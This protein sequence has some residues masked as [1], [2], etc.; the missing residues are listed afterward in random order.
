MPQTILVSVK[1]I[2]DFE[3]KRL[4]SASTG[5][6]NGTSETKTFRGN[7]L[8]KGLQK[9]NSLARKIIIAVIIK[10]VLVIVAGFGIVISLGDNQMYNTYVG[11]LG[12]T[13][14]SWIIIAY[15]QQFRLIQDLC[16]A[17]TTKKSGVEYMKSI[18]GGNNLQL[19]GLLTFKVRQTRLKR[20]KRR[21][22]MRFYQAHPRSRLSPRKPLDCDQWRR[23]M[24]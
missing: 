3:A 23:W 15:Y 18:K 17:A 5:T 13:A 7:L 12:Y 16:V 4:T 24:R 11:Q 10:I 20:Q 22:Q 21:V 19:T 2:K 9:E 6:S 14:S 1:K 8:G